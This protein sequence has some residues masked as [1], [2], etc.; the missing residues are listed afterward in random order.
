MDA[1]VVEATFPPS[2]QHNPLL[3]MATIMSFWA[4]VLICLQWIYEIVDANRDLPAPAASYI[5][6]AR[7]VRFWLVMSALIVALPRLVQ[8][9]LWQKLGAVPR[10]FISAVSWMCVIPAAAMVVFAWWTNKQVVATESGFTIEHG[11]VPAV[12]ST[13]QEKTKG[14]MMLVLIFSISFATTFVRPSTDA[15]PRTHVIEPRKG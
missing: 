3:A 15:H 9:M 11:F 14:V 4:V 12:P 1:F 8:L 6:V 13:R 7:R 10:E 2:L 5:A